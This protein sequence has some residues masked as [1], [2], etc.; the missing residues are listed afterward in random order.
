[1]VGP[2]VT[3]ELQPH[4]YYSDQ[5][6]LGQELVGDNQLPYSCTCFQLRTNQ[7]KPK[8]DMRSGL[9]QMWVTVGDLE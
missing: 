6:K 5:T 3:M 2:Y 9:C 4:N 8:P 1:M 7:R